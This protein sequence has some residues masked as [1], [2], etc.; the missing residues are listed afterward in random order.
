MNIKDFLFFEKMLTPQIV[1]ALYWL[2]LIGVVVG[3]IAAI[4][5]GEFIKGLMILV[6]GIIAVRIYCEFITVIF[7]LNKNVKA[8]AETK[9]N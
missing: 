3:G 6:F 4:F 2:S 9:N 5:T 7:Q 1:V 8:I